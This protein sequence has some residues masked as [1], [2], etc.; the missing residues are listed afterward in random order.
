MKK[1]LDRTVAFYKGR[2]QMDRQAVA[3]MRKGIQSQQRTT[4]VLQNYRKS[5]IAFWNRVT[6]EPLV[7]AGKVYFLGMQTD[8]VQEF[9]PYFPFEPSQL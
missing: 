5:G 1:L 9:P 6:I 3:Q 7:V 8:I 2:K 4:V